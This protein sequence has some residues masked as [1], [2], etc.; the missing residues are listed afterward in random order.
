[1]RAERSDDE[2]PVV[3]AMLSN[4]TRGI[5]HARHPSLRWQ[6]EYR[7]GA[8]SLSGGC[9]SRQRSNANGQRGWKWQPEGGASGEG[10][11]PC[12]G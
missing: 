3:R 8:I 6:A 4:K 2:W 1:M 10:I 7:P 9:S 12:T 11:S 5:T